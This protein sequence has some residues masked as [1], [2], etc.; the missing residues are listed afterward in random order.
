ME[1]E[2]ITEKVEIEN[3]GDRDLKEIAE[4]LKLEIIVGI[5]KSENIPNLLL[6]GRGTAKILGD[7][8]DFG[9]CHT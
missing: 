2:T 9:N 4:T 3:I 7:S 5:S 6:K 8:R 1:E